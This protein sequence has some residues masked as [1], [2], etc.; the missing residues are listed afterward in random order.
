MCTTLE[1]CVPLRLMRDGEI[2]RI[3]ST[4]LAD[5]RGLHLGQ[6]R[7][8]AGIVTSRRPAP[9]G[10]RA[11]SSAWPPSSNALG[12]ALMSSDSYP[13]ELIAASHASGEPH[14]IPLFEAARRGLINVLVQLDPRSRV[15]TAML[16]SRYPTAILLMANED[17]QRSVHDWDQAEEL[18]RWARFIIL[19]AG[20]PDSVP[21]LG[22]ALMASTHERSLLVEL[23]P[24]AHPEWVALAQRVSRG[25]VIMNVLPSMTWS[26]VAGV[27]RH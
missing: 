3:A 6:K 12:R 21:Y 14:R 2:L 26:E 16:E 5:G 27:V 1:P 7:F 19:N 15:P 10:R 4:M 23:P 24:N 8:L 9:C 22:A 13:A 17:S 25:T 20:E 18:L 11:S